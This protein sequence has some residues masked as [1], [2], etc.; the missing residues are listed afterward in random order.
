MIS[1]YDGLDK[2]NSMIKLTSWERQIVHT[3]K[4]VNLIPPLQK[5]SM[6]YEV[7]EVVTSEGMR[8]RAQ[9]M[10]LDFGNIEFV[11]MNDFFIEQFDGHSCGPI[12]CL[13]VMHCVGEI[14][15]DYRQIAK[16]N[17]LRKFI[18]RRYKELVEKYRGHRV[19]P[20]EREHDMDEEAR[21][22]IIDH[23]NSPVKT[24]PIVSNSNRQNKKND[25]EEVDVSPPNSDDV[26]I[27]NDK[28]SSLKSDD[29]V[30]SKD[31]TANPP[32]PSTLG[33]TTNQEEEDH[34]E[35]EDDDNISSKH[36]PREADRVRAESMVLRRQRQ[37]V[38]AD[39][40][41]KYQKKD[42]K[43]RGLERGSIIT[44]RI[45]ARDHSHA[46]GLFAVVLRVGPYGGALVA[47][48]HGVITSSGTKAD[49]WMPYTQYRIV[50]DHL[51]KTT[52]SSEMEAVRQQ[53]ING[54]Y[55]YKNAPR[56]SI[57]QYHGIVVGATSPLKKGRCMCAK[58]QC[59][60]R[61]GCHRKGHKCSSS[62]SCSG[63]CFNK[64]D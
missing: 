50:A 6:K 46:Q 11:C 62:C 51:T 33:V 32:L 45:D 29:V 26:S 43:A 35:Q 3:L 9:I 14:G 52:L 40:M 63:N 37:E 20:H 48:E 23:E 16:G 7:N 21:A 8:K 47:C 19:L 25:V 61:C 27:K 53:I 31:D 39:N 59:T 17:N 4:C 15:D 58:G 5:W 54:E 64:A 60:K 38:Q 36:H 34:D 44:I 13:K 42:L 12:A 30:Q 41:K 57:L 56:I 1:V 24:T 49:F 10:K 55:D 28:V 22:I 2:H 18:V